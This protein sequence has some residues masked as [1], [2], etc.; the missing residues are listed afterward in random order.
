MHIITGMLLAGL[1]KRGQ[2]TPNLLPMLRT[3]PVQTAHCLPGRI[4]FRI[5]SL[6]DDSQQADL[7]REKLPTLRGVESLN[8]TVSTGSVLVCY[9][10]KELP[11]ELLFAALVR[12]LGL[13]KE[14]E[15]TPQPTVVK[16]LRSVMDSLNRVVYDRTAGLLDFQSSILILLAAVG[17][18]KLMDGR[19]NVL[20]AGATLLWWG[21]NRLLDQGTE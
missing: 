10:E 19:A 14:L 7:L 17:V 16:E 1:L 5:P 12:L 8:V 20:P 2:K 15:T 21:L 4:R 3:G 18:K 11:G 13:E 9:R 6:I